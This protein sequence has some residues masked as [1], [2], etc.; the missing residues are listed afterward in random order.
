MPLSTSHQHN[1]TQPNAPVNKSLTHTLNDPTNRTRT[2]HS[3]MPLSASHQHIDRAI[4]QTDQEPNTPIN[5]SP[6]HTLSDT[7]DR[8]RTE[9]SLMPLSTSHQ[10]IHWTIQQTEHEPNTPVNTKSSTRTLSDPTNRTRIKHTCQQVINTYTKRSKNTI[11]T[12]HTC[13][14][15]VNT[16][17]ERSDK[18]NTNRTHLST[19]HRHIHW[20]I[21][22][23]EHEPST[24]GLKLCSRL[25]LSLSL[26]FKWT[27]HVKACCEEIKILKDPANNTNQTQPYITP[28]WTSHR[29]RDNTIQYGAKLTHPNASVNNKV[30]KAQIWWA[31][32]LNTN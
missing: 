25:S 6:T 19:S 21:Q 24:V 1:Q 26:S 12:Q 28:S 7:T 4:Q 23:A 10:H 29:K 14:Q 16:Y 15:A 13:Q 32:K 30:I 31:N 9:H 3:P 20:T 18:Q 11:W 5:K 27:K 8:T 22:Q 2:K 17:T